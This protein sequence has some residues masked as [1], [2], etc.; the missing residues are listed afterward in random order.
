VNNKVCNLG[1]TF[2]VGVDL[3]GTKVRGGIAGLDGHVLCE[4]VE[5]TTPAAGR[6]LVP[7]LS[8][9]VSRLAAAVGYDTSA[10]VA[11]AIG[12]AGIPDA[13]SGRFGRAP[14]LGNL[15][16]FSL[17]ADLELVLGHQVVLENDVNI[18]AL[19][20]LHEG[21]GTQHDSFAFVSVG[22]GIGVGLILDR[23]LWAGVN[24]GAGEVGYLPLGADPLQPTNHRRGPLEEVVAGDAIVR[25]YREYSTST[26]ESVVDAAEV[27]NLAEQG[28]VHAIASLDEEAKWIAFALVAI[29]AV[30]NPGL[31]VLG[32]GIGTR[33]ELHEPVRAWLTRLGH[34]EFEIVVSS[35]GSH[36][37]IAGAVRLAIDLAL[38]P[39]ERETS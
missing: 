30:I 2:V 34:P 18:A 35:L 38:Q 23:Q 4:I 16:E 28:D 31:F 9:L 1:S 36:A 6:D 33:L 12:G 26:A 19:G 39:R 8:G 29:D 3:G 15:E 14:N 13:D 5:A 11:T 20:E 10:V 17:A 25:R 22:T 24:G 21:V 32:G 27:F 7:Q 37:S